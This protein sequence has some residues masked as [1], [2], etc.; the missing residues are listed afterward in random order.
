[1][2]KEDY[3]TLPEEVQVFIWEFVSDFNDELYKKYDFEIDQ[4]DNLPSAG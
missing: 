1:M 3:K 4:F 2:L